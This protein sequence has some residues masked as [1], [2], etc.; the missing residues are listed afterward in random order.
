MKYKTLRDKL[1]AIE[2]DDK[3]LEFWKSV[4][5]FAP[6]EKKVPSWIVERVNELIKKLEI[7]DQN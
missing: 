5:N 3:L 2:T 6:P 4:I 1:Q 7:R